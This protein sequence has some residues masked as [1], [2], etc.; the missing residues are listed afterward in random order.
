MTETVRA[1]MA[2]EINR[3]KSP[4]GVLVTDCEDERRE[5]GGH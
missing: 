2:N 3:A 5:V 1:D 4:G